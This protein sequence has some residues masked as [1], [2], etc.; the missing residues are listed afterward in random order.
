M[1]NYLI[2]I[3][4]LFFLSSCKKENKNRIAYNQETWYELLEK[5]RNAKITVIDTF[6]INQKQKAQNAIK[7]GELT[8]FYYMGMMKVFRNNKEMKELLSKHNIKIDSTLTTCFAPASGF[9]YYCYEEEMRKAIDEKYGTNFIDS[10]RLEADKIYVSK[11]LNK[12]YEF[13]DCDT[14]ARYPRAKTYREHFNNY[15][16]DY[17]KSFKYPVDYKYKNEESYSYTTADFI[18]HKDGSVSNFETETIFQNPDNNKYRNLF[19]K[20]IIDF[21]KKTNWT[22]AKSAGFVV[23]SKMS[24]YISY[25]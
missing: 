22:P 17:L 19:N 25:Q 8:Y 11:H 4:Y 1:K 6:C 7:K 9:E 3:L 16:E 14:I 12:I 21:V 2:L 10:L 23:N 13:E 5:D 18:L 24:V 20:R 15:E